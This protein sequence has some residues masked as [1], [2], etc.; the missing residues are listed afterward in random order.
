MSRRWSSWGVPADVDGAELG[1]GGDPRGGPQD[2]VHGGHREG[3]PGSGT[4]TLGVERGNHLA[5][6]EALVMLEAARLSDRG[7][8]VGVGEQQAHGSND[9]VAAQT[10]GA[11]DEPVAVGDTADELAAGA[12]DVEGGADALG[13]LAPARTPRRRGARC[14]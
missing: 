7:L 1:F 11:E 5:H 3:A 2:R 13:Q 8:L 12:L 6:A 14:A 10:I 9:A 4:T